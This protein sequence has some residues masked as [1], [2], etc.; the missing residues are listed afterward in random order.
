MGSGMFSRISRS[1]TED[2]VETQ[3]DRSYVFMC[4]TTL[5]FNSSMVNWLT[6]PDR[7]TMELA[8]LLIREGSKGNWNPSDVCFFTY[9]RRTYE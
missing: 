6:T 7:E 2:L 9:W 1:L 3:S 8:V 4:F 5:L